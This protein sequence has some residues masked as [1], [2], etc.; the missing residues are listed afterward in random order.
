MIGACNTRQTRDEAVCFPL[1]LPPLHL[2]PPPLPPLLPSPVPPQ[3]YS[4][5]YYS[6][7]PLRPPRTR[8][9]PRRHNRENRV[10][11]EWKKRKWL[12]QLHQNKRANSRERRSRMK[13]KQRHLLLPLPPPL[14]PLHPLHRVSLGLSASQSLRTSVPVSSTLFSF[15]VVSIFLCGCLISCCFVRSVVA[16]RSFQDAWRV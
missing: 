4:L 14:H 3:N 13:R 7:R 11:E 2:L 9:H 12:L 6:L 5:R 15:S 10:S 8:S 16:C 1:P